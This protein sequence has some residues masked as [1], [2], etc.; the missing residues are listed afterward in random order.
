[1]ALTVAIGFV[2][3]DA[4]VVIEAIV[5]R[6]EQGMTPAEAAIAGAQQVG[7]T[8]VSISA[9]LV[10]VF[11]PLLF[12]GGII[13]RLLHEFATTLTVAIT[14]SAI[15]ALTLA[16]MLCALLL[17]RAEPV[18]RPGLVGG[19][20]V[21]S[22]AAGSRLY[23]AALGWVLGRPRLMIGLTVGAFAATIGLYIVAPKGLLPPQDTGLIEGGTI[24]DPS[25]SFQA[26]QMRQRA[27]VAALLQDPAVA[28]ISSQVGVINGFTPL[29]RGG[30]TVGLRPRN[31]RD[32][33]SQQVLARLRPALDAIGGMQTVLDPAQD[34]RGGVR[35]GGGIQFVLLGADL[36]ELRLWTARLEHALRGVKE[37]TQVSSDLD[38]EGPDAHIV[39]DRETAA[40]LGVSVQAIDDMLDTA[41]T[42][43]QSVTLYG[44][45]NQHKVV[46]EVDPEFQSGPE[47]L[48]FLFVSDAAGHQI[49]LSSVARVE[50]RSAAAS[51]RHQGQLPAATISFDPAPG[52]AAG[53]AIDR[54][55][56]AAAALHLPST[57]RTEY[58]GNAKFLVESL[59]S[60]PI[61]I[62]AALLSIYIVLGALYESFAQPLTILSTLPSAG[63]GALLALAVT[64]TELSVVSIVGIL[65]LMGIAKKNAIMLVDAALHIER[66]GELSAQEAIHAACLERFRPIMMTTFAALLGALPLALS[67]GAG[68][69]LR[70]PLGIAITGG[71]L[72]SQTLT[73]FTTPVIYLALRRRNRLSTILRRARVAWSRQAG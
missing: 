40:R 66:T 50:M 6:V 71:L 53:T 69:E 56:A 70:Q 7:F 3:D 49:P 22:G 60:Q 39:I 4:I 10:A 30:L 2:V 26:M 68:A 36:D 11:I 46:L 34:L 48:G 20:I 47:A 12:M 25:V 15:L 45:R 23:G 52:V 44:E 51:V 65:L 31:E 43:H 32:A 73:L 64:G 57:I 62:A 8:I 33:T 1:M 42:Q 17:R 35:Q 9:S 61:L 63:L 72:V 19:A 13:G 24:A 5:R 21:S 58:A 29:H 28:T 14:L 55:R 59:S 37:I 18:R 38:A 54:V 67:T 41:F 27:V 16:P